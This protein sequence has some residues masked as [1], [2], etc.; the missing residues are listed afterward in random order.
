MLPGVSLCVPMFTHS[1]AQGS[2]QGTGASPGQPYVCLQSTAYRITGLRVFY[3]SR[4][5]GAALLLT[6]DVCELL[7]PSA[8]PRLEAWLA[9]EEDRST[10]L[11]S[12]CLP[13]PVPAPSSSLRPPFWLLPWAVKL[14]CS[15]AAQG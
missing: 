3:T 11:C 2:Y 10:V 5:T 9:R 8:A 6:T 4:L 14:A 13:W 12:S 1:A 15:G 7:T